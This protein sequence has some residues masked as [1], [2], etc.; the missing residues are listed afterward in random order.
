MPSAT[1]PKGTYIRYTDHHGVTR[2]GVV[3]GTDMGRSKYEVG[4]RVGGWGRWIWSDGGS[5]VFPSQ[6][7]VVTEQEANAPPDNKDVD[8]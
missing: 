7:Q 2:Y 6:V 1:L 4:D 3:V 5:W 8:A